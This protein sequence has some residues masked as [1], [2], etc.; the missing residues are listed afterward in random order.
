MFKIYLY[1]SA[2][3]TLESSEHFLY[4]RPPSQGKKENTS[5]ESALKGYCLW[6]NPNCA[7]YEIRR[8][9]MYVCIRVNRCTVLLC[10]HLFVFPEIFHHFLISYIFTMKARKQNN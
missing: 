1:V 3:R 5:T 8:G 7:Q 10:A 4:V 2:Y 6:M 9:D